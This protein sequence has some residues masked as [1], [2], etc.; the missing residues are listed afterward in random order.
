M[1]IE[2]FKIERI[3]RSNIK[4]AD[5]NPRFIDEENKEKLKEGIK[6]FGLVEPLIWNKRTGT[7]VSGHQRLSI[8][9]KIQKNKDYELT[10]SVIDVNEKDEKILNVQL[11]NK[12]MQGEFDIESLGNLS[13]DYDINISD[14]GFSDLDIEMMYGANEKFAE[15]LPDTKEVTQAKRDI[16]EVKKD[17]R[18]MMEQYKN[19]QSADFYFIVVCKDQKEKD[20]ILTKMNV[21]IYEQYVT[22]EMLRRLIENG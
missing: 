22:V 20:E 14:F 1:N 15:L 5:Y 8:I 6:K 4:I 21:P 12:S 7:L 9:D 10:V 18:E 2:N 16:E 17:R 11:N 19:E 13:L 3:K